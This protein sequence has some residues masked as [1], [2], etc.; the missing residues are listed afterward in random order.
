MKKLTKEQK[1]KLEKEAGDLIRKWYRENVI[2]HLVPADWD[3]KD[4][5]KEFYK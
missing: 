5:F 2:P 4:L 3:T 1:L